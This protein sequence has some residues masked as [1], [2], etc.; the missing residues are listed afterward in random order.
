MEILNYTHDGIESDN[1]ELDAFNMLQYPELLTY[2][3]LPQKSYIENSGSQIFYFESL[4]KVS[5]EG[6]SIK[7]KKKPL[8]I[9]SLSKAERQLI[10]DLYQNDFEYFGYS[11]SYHWFKVK[12]RFSNS[13]LH[14]LNKIKNLPSSLKM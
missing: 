12:T 13:I 14:F 3:Y 11:K 1:I 9:P 8:K 6:V 10:R 7:I 5:L 4:D 2:F